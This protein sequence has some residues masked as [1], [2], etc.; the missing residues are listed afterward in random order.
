MPEQRKER[1]ALPVLGKLIE[2]YSVET[3]FASQTVI[4]GH[5]LVRNALVMV[6]ALRRGG[7][8][9]ILCDAHPSPAD[10]AVRAAA[11]RHRV[12]ILA[13]DKAVQ[14][15]DLYLDVGS[16]LGRRRTPRAAAEVTRT[17]ILH[18]E[19]IDCPVVSADDC[20]SKY[21]EGFFGTGDGFVRAWQKVRPDDPLEG[22][23]VVQFGYGKIGRGIAHQTQKA[24]MQVTVVDLEAA[25]CAQAE[26]EG[27]PAVKTAA[28]TALKRAL[29]QAEVVIAVTGIPGVLG[30][31]ILPGWIRA[32]RPVLVNLG[33]EDEFGPAFGEDEILG[34]RSIPLNFHLPQPTRNR[35]VDPVLAAHLLALEAFLGQP[36]AYPAGVHPLPPE[37]DHW[38]KHTWRTAWPEEDLTGIG[39][40]IGLD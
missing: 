20:Q 1:E 40:L 6:E 27:F 32:N 11:A 29:A 28:R 23:W 13:I 33:A 31:G 25:A 35:Y 36:H 8:E 30:Q 39:D 4:F 19:K 15:G 38:V 5:I 3:P 9:V 10:T 26:A 14:A 12:P 37:L 22:K 24:G 16:V 18:Y 2:R 21:I 7:A 34:G 17:G